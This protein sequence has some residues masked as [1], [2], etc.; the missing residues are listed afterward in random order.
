MEQVKK[1]DEERN[2]YA[3]KATGGGHTFYIEGEDY[4]WKPSKYL[5]QKCKYAVVG[6]TFEAEYRIEVKDNGKSTLYFEWETFNWCD[7]IVQPDNK[8]IIINASAEKERSMKTNHNKLA[9]EALG[10]MTLEE[11][12]HGHWNHLTRSQQQCLLARIMQYLGV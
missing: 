10:A 3:G 5:N 7:E 6:Q 2:Y 4:T 1:N 9:D 11:I 8:F 12:R